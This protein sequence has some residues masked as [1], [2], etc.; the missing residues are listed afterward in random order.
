MRLG[1]ADRGNSAS[2]SDLTL[3]SGTGSMPAD[4]KFEQCTLISSDQWDDIAYMQPSLFCIASAGKAPTH[5]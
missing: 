2:I 3:S 4:F 1:E 5:P